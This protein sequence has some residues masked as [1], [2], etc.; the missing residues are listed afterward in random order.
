MILD[1]YVARSI[2]SHAATAL[3]GLI[4]L[5]ASF[6][7]LEQQDDIGQGRY[8]LGLAAVRTVLLI[9]SWMADFAGLAVLLGTLTG[10]GQLQQGSEITAMRSAGYT[11]TRLV[12]VAMSA[13]ALVA[14]VA[15]LIGE[16]AGPNLSELAARLKTE[17]RMGTANS[18]QPG[19]WWTRDG[20]RIV[21]VERSGASTAVTVFDLGP[22]GLLD[23]VT[24]TKQRPLVVENGVRML[25][26]AATRYTESGTTTQHSTSLL[27][28]GEPL[29]ALLRIAE[30]QTSYPSLPELAERAG[31]LASAG[32]DARLAR[33]DMHSRIA[34]LFVAPLLA[35][36]AVLASLTGLRA[37]RQGAR[38]VLGLAVG[39]ILALLRDLARS[40]V[41]VFDWTSA[42]AAWVPV[43]T[44]VA[45]L[46]AMLFVRSR[47][48]V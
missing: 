20:A 40:S 43:V 15:T 48:K 5:V 17:S 23:A 1:R 29:R 10:F 25:H 22:T 41:L 38:L 19:A 18:T 14:I 13:G 4:L 11:V 24:T 47:V 21:S 35:A 39:L 36:I 32:L 8:T 45:V 12:S 37:A 3:A 46:G 2:A 9:P 44:S 16:L 42:P 34:R 7:F 33:F 6:S 26:A 27:I 30:D 28:P 31:V